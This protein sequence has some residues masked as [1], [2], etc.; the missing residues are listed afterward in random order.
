[1]TEEKVFSDVVEDLPP[2]MLVD[3]SK[4]MKHYHCSLGGLVQKKMP[5]FEAYMINP[6]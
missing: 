1:M 3:I 4:Q 6:S 2:K 5:D